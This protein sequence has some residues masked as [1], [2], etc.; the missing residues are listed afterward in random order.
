M[1][2]FPLGK[3]QLKFLIIA[4]D[5]FT[6]WVKAKPMKTITEAKITS[7][8]WK[9]IICRFGVPCVI[10]SDNGKQF[11]NPK[12]CFFQDLRVKNHYSSPRHPQANGQTKAYSKSSKLDLRGENRAWP[13]ELQNVLWAYRTTTRVPTGETPFRLTFGPEAIIPVEVGLTSF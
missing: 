8:V 4:I 9:N 7:F 1:G 12:F 3:K 10:I 6:K 11:D 13:E 2:P 5:Y